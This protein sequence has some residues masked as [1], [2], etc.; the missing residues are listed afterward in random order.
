MQ[1]YALFL[2]IRA[3]RCDLDRRVDDPKIRVGND[4][5]ESYRQSGSLFAL[6]EIKTNQ[7]LRN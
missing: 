6:T 5:A 2:P 3:S 1:R 7:S 4:L